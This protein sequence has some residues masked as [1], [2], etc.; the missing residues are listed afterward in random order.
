MGD[1]IRLAGRSIAFQCRCGRATRTGHD[2]VSHLNLS[3]FLVPLHLPQKKEKFEFD[4]LVPIRQTNPLRG[5]VLVGIFQ[6]VHSLALSVVA[7]SLGGMC[8]LASLWNRAN[9]RH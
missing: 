4:G 8:Q 6:R 5:L 3:A 7:K 9:Q 2:I 1:D